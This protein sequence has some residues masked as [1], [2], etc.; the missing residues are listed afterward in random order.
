MKNNFYALLGMIIGGAAGTT[1]M[2]I[3]KEDEKRNLL[4][5]VDKFKQ[6]YNLLNQWL[7]LKQQNKKM[8][9]YLLKREINSIAIYG[10]GNIGELLH[11]E[12]KET[13]VEVAYAIDNCSDDMYSE[14]KVYNLQDNLPEVDLIIVT[15]VFDYESIKNHLNKIT[16]INVQSLEDILF[17]MQEG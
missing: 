9:D 8:S 11:Q 6:Y 13:N 15:A 3:K 2:Y 7:S 16:S 1:G 14:L 17:D 5:K 4:Q 12:L 10:L